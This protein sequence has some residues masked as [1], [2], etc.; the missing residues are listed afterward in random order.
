MRKWDREHRAG[1]GPTFTAQPAGT[2][3]DQL[4]DGLVI[5]KTHVRL[6]ISWP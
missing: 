5:D 2:P 6:T 4:P 1:G 3:N